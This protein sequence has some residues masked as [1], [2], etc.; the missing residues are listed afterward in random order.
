M[1]NV[2]YLL[3]ATCYA[4]L[5]Q[6]TDLA[7]SLSRK[8]DKGNGMDLGLQLSNLQ[9]NTLNLFATNT[10][11]ECTKFIFESYFLLCSSQLIKSK[12]GLLFGVPIPEEFSADGDVI[13]REIQNALQECAEQKITGKN[14]TPYVLARYL[15]PGLAIP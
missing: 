14:V 2:P 7:R 9:A 10:A 3:L 1:C 4:S 11:P 12:S 8:I 13:E 15:G 6:C 5:L